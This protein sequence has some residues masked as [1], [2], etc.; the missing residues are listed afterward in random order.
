M[1][2]GGNQNVKNKNEDNIGD[3]NPIR[4]RGYYCD[5]ETGLYYLNAR[6][7]DPKLGR[8]ISPDTFNI[9]DDTMG[10]INGL[11]LYMYCKDNPVMYADPS[12]CFAITTFLIGM[13]IAA[14]TGAVVGAFSYTV[15]ESVSYFLTGK[16][17]WS[18]SQFAGSI[19]G[20]AIGG[21]VSVIPGV[22][23]ML[24]AGITGF[25]STSIGMMLQNK[26]E[27]TNYS[28]AQI[29]FVSSINGLL[30]ASMAGLSDSIKIKGLN[31][32]RNSY[33]AI[34]KAINTKFYNGTISRISYK[35]FSKVLT[36]NM[37]GSL[38][39]SGVSGIMDATNAN[40]WMVK[41]FNERTGL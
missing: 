30:S 16:F 23:V 12:G 36:Y 40:D 4:Y 9:L 20:G 27:G 11:N 33:S 10:E 7:Y 31:S 14:L 5:K 2:R 39:G 8:F 29:L 21:A 35:T 41:W 6:Y 28:F 17:S 25:A 15:S 13:G 24:S 37:L 19:L 34:S 1:M 22:G 38:I 3:I 32:G 18:W 26:F